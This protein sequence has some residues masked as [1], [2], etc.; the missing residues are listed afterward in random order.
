MK[1]WDPSWD[2]DTDGLS[3]IALRI[4]CLFTTFVPIPICEFCLKNDVGKAESIIKW[5]GWGE[6]TYMEKNEES[7]MT[8]LKFHH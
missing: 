4:E 3:V 7:F 8:H 5:G 2:S 6:V 1:F